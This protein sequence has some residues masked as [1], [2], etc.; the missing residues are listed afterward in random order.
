M[1][2]VPNATPVLIRR[3]S[4]RSFAGLYVGLVLLA[5]VVTI[6]GV[7]AEIARPAVVVTVALAPLVIGVLW[8]LL[9]RWSSEYRLYEDGLEVES[10]ILARRIENLQLFRVRDLGLAQSLMARLLGVG[11]VMVTSTDQSSPRLVL[12]GVDDP[13]AVYDA[14]RSRVS[15]SQATR[16]TMILEEERPDTPHATG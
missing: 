3:T 14:L 11:N 2:Q 5:S 13:R 7:K 8:A 10:G 6:V 9:V 1:S 15:R 4:L 12:R 16:R